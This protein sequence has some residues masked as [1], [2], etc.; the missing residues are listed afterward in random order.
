MGKF[1]HQTLYNLAV[2]V[3][4]LAG[5]L[6]GPAVGDWL[7]LRNALWFTFVMQV[8]AGLVFWWVG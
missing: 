5:S 4:I 3:G 6:L 7:G 2:N 1:D 8:L